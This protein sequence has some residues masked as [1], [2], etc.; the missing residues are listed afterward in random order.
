MAK[1]NRFN[2]MHIK[3]KR[4]LIKFLNLLDQPVRFNPFVFSRFFCFEFCRV[5]FESQIFV[6][7]LEKGNKLLTPNLTLPKT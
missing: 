4:K 5:K 6:F 2:G 1:Q 3:R 7:R